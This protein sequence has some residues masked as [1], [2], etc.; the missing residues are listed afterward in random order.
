MPFSS[1]IASGIGTIVPGA[2]FCLS[3]APVGTGFCGNNKG[4]D[5]DTS[6]VSLNS[7]IP[8]IA[9]NV[10]Y[11]TLT[12]AS[13]NSGSTVLF[14]GWDINFGLSSAFDQCGNPHGG[15]CQAALQGEVPSEA[16]TI[17]GG[18]TTPE[19]SSLMLFGSGILGIAG[20][21]RRR[22]LE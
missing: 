12:N 11:L 4:Y 20:L 9:G 16:F 7:A 6:N 15:V 18:G 21:L 5:V 3:G 22:L 1:D 14:D 13:D 2:P 17:L 8:I 19:P 10:Y